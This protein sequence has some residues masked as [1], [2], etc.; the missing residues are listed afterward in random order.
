MP[1]TVQPTAWQRL[2]GLLLITESMPAD[3]NGR[4]NRAATCT[5]TLTP[6][7]N[8]IIDQHPRHPQVRMMASALRCS[9]RSLS[10]D[11][12]TQ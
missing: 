2:S 3:A 10:L 5:F 9:C 7:L 12:A 1:M 4:L 8:F 11:C 6:D